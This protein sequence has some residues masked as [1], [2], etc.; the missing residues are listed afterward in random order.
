MQSKN[1]AWHAEFEQ[2]IDRLTAVGMSDALGSAL[3]RA[4]YCNDRQAGQRAIHLL[5][6]KA[7]QRLRV[8]MSY[9]RS[10]ATVALREWMVDACEKCHGTGTTKDGA[11][12]STCSKCNGTG[13][14]SYSDSERALCAGFPVESWSKH[15]KR[16]EITL[17]CMYGSVAEVTGRVRELLSA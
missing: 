13:K 12:L 6:N 17:N 15:T 1:L 2:A 7:A 4:K 16:F 3:F 8:E 10:L 9:A 11:S 5:T 14:K